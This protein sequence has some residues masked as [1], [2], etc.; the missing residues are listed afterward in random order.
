MGSFA[1]GERSDSI[2]WFISLLLEVFT[3]RSRCFCS[4]KAGS[5][6]GVEPTSWPVCAGIC[7][8]CADPEYNRRYKKWIKSSSFIFFNHLSA[9]NILPDPF[10]IFRHRVR[11]VTVTARVPVLPFVFGEAIYILIRLTSNII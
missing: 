1:P 11:V 4:F 2:I 7:H 5:Y 9:P 10:H 6:F 3:W 8:T